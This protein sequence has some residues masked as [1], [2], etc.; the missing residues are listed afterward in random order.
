MPFR[1]LATD[2]F[3]DVIFVAAETASED[4]GVQLDLDRFEPEERDDIV[5]L[6]MSN[7]IKFLC[8]GDSPVDGIFVTIPSDAVLEAVLECMQAGVPVV[9]IN[10]GVE[11]AE[12][13]GLVHYIGQ[14]EYNSG[15]GAAQKLITKGISKGWCL[16]HEVGTQ[17]TVQ[18]CQG[19]EDAFA[20]NPEVEYMGQIVVPRDNVEQYKADVQIII[21]DDGLWDGYGLLLTGQIQVPAAIELLQEHPNVVIGTF[22][23]SDTVFGALDAGQISFGIDQQPYLQ[24]YMPVP[25]LKYVIATKQQLSNA[26]IESGPSFVLSSPS[27]EQLKCEAEFFDVCRVKEGEDPDTGDG[28]PDDVTNGEITD[29]GIGGRSWLPCRY[30]I[31]LVAI[32]GMMLSI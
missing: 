32:V 12:E 6:K 25:L 8:S 28:S 16:N 18:R 29:T 3:W 4:M 1:Y 20:L 21:D 30:A 19:M 9:A 11:A 10:A 14:L 23:L 13:Y 17:T 5:H 27:K 2:G 22:D 26:V 31:T 24:G 15:F 7:K